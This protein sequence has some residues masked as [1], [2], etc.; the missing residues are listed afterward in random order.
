MRYKVTLS[1]R[2]LAYNG[3]QIQPNH[4]SVQELVE[5]ALSTALQQEIKVVGA[6][7]TDTGV[8]ASFYIAHFDSKIMIE[9]LSQLVF[10]CNTLLPKDIAFQKIERVKDDF[11]ARFD[12]KYRSY[13][14]QITQN[15]NPF[16]INSA[17]YIKRQL[18][19][20][21]MNESCD[22][23][24]KHQNFK[25]FSKVK[26]SVYTYNCNIIEAEWKLENNLV[27]FEIKAN[28]FLRNMVRAIVGTMIEVGLHTL[29]L[30]EFNQIIIDQD[31][32]KAGKSV[33][34]HALFLT[35][36]GY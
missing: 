19:L 27:C 22:I 32:R 16:V 24:K 36:I 1:Y 26:T 2:G 7:R 28:R 33:P 9:E 34:A 31:R 25:A 15:K 10:K 4:L 14:Y 12:A 6:G 17:Y 20:K 35:D 13:R 29:T 8:H 11:H 21:M 5:S 18:D 30:K 3:W 23:L